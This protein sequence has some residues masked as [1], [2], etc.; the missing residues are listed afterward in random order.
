MINYIFKN[1]SK[2]KIKIMLTCLM[3]IVST[4]LVNFT[5]QVLFNY[6]DVLNDITVNATYKKDIESLV[7]LLRIAIVI[8]IGFAYTIV[9]NTYSIIFY[10]RSEEFNLLYNLGMD[11]KRIKRMLY[12]EVSIVGGISIIIGETISTIFAEVFMKKYDF[13]FN[14]IYWNAS[15]LVFIFT[16]LFLIYI[17][18]IIMRKIDIGINEKNAKKIYSIGKKE[19]FRKKIILIV[20]IVLILFRFIS[21]NVDTIY[22]SIIKDILFYIGVICILDGAMILIFSI[23]N[24]LAK[25]F[26]VNFLYIGINENIYNFK[27]VKTLILSLIISVNLVLGMI[28]FFDS[29]KNSV[30]NFIDNNIFYSSICIMNDFPNKSELELQKFIKD[31]FNDKKVVSTLSISV[32]DKN[33]RNAILVG[34]DKEYY[35]IENV[36]FLKSGDKEKIFE[37]G[38]EINCIFSAVKAEQ[39]NLSLGDSVKYKLDDLELNVNIVEEYRPL[40]ISQAFVSKDILS[41]KLFNTKGMYNSLY[42]VDYSEDEI[43]QVMNYLDVKDYEINDINNLKEDYKK[44]A[45]SGT[46]MIETLLYISLFF[47]VILIINMFLLSFQE[48]VKQYSL[49]RIIGVK[50]TTILYSIIMESSIIFVLGAYIGWKIGI[51]FIKAA[52]GYMITNSSIHADVWIDVPKMISILS[53]AFLIIIISVIIIGVRSLNRDCLKEVYRE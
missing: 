3:L 39:N 36:S 19:I 6:M 48:R 44:Q 35:D 7:T 20:G 13:D 43:E 9:I 12:L 11:K 17:V 28:G 1:I 45:V 24:C 49:L 47:T 40:N 14:E 32:K 46:E 51:E 26:K 38:S 2:N 18:N 22:Y 37:S 15:L 31:N 34:I 27:R 5:V 52:L 8:L 53:I 21:V 42:F 41:E 50:K 10:G 29:V 23:I 30:V 4:A 16:I 33:N 25:Y